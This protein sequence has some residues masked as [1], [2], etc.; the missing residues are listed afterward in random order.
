MSTKYLVRTRYYPFV[1]LLRTRIKIATPKATAESP[2]KSPLVR[3]FA[4]PSRAKCSRMEEMLQANR[5]AAKTA[6]P[7]K[8]FLLFIESNSLP[9]FVYF[10]SIVPAPP[11]ATMGVTVHCRSLQC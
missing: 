6:N 4:G 10:N 1:C 8:K 7:M 3:S 5:P 9:H 11:A 2:S